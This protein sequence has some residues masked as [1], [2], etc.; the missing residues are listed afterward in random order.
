MLV[1]DE[2]SN[3]ALTLSLCSFGDDRLKENL[4]KLLW[5]YPKLIEFAFN[6]ELA[7]VRRKKIEEH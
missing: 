2:R 7:K 3:T 1:S 5:G 4:G 6:S